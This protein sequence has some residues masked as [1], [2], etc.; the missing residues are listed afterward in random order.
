MLIK[1]KKK[2]TP[3][4]KLISEFFER[5]R[6]EGIISSPDITSLHKG[7]VIQFMNE[8]DR[9]TGLGYSQDK[10]RDVEIETPECPTRKDAEGLLYQY[11]DAWRKNVH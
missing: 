7:F 6:E 4:Q 2:K 8:G 3:E 11:I 9:W 5:Y 1:T 10:G